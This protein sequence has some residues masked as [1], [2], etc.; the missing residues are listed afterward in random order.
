M[1]RVTKKKEI[2]KNTVLL[3]CKKCN[4]RENFNISD[5]KQIPGL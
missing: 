3:N 4:S 5:K 2:V 1:T